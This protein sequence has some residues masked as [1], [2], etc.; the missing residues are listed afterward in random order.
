M[1]KSLSKVTSTIV[2]ISGQ[3]TT[4]CEAF[5]SNRKYVRVLSPL[6][7]IDESLH[8]ITDKIN[9][10]NDQNISQQTA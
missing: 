1:R 9:V 2:L 5:A 8:Q 6:T 3:A 7:E 4:V 10:G